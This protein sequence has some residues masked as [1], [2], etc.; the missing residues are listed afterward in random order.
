MNDI[1]DIK[2]IIL[3]LPFS[4]FLSLL[5]IFFIV[6]LYFVIFSKKEKIVVEKKEEKEF[7]FEYN[8]ILKD[9]EK[10]IENYNNSDFFSKINHLLKL[11]VLEKYNLD[12]Y[13]DTLEEVK[14]SNLRN[15]DNEIYLEFEKSYKNQYLDM[16]FDSEIKKKFLKN[17]KK[18]INK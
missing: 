14:K 13:S 3:W 12:L 4:I 7:I 17:I 2:D 10:N 9:L 16:S 5:S 18:I 15:L 8:N 11:K 6:I 1:Y